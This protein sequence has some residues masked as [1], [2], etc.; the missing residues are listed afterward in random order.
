ME[1]GYSICFNKWALDRS[2]K[3]ELGLLLIISSLTAERGYCYASNTYLAKLFKTNGP[4][5]SR[6]ISKLKDKGY[7]EIE[8][9]KR[10]TEITNR[11][12][13]LSK[14]ITDRYQKWKTGIIKND[15]DNNINNNNT[16]RIIPLNNFTKEDLDNLYE[17]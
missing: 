15:K 14:M 9:E 1:E 17:N 12:I 13:R 6:K 8:Y 5:I 7:I 10:G 2:I 11:Y 4:T 3:N 16:R